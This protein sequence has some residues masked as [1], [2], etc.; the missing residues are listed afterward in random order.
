MRQTWSSLL[1]G[2]RK[3]A[4]AAAAG[5]ASP[6]AAWGCLGGR[7]SWL[8]GPPRWGSCHA[9][10]SPP[11]GACTSERTWAKGK[12]DL[13][14]ALLSSLW[15][16]FHVAIYSSES[17][18]AMTTSVWMHQGL[19][20]LP[21][22][23]PSGMQ[24]HLSGGCKDYCCFNSQWQSGHN[25]SYLLMSYT[26]LSW[27]QWPRS[28]TLH[29]SFCL[30]T[31]RLV[32]FC[33]SEEFSDEGKTS[34]AADSAGLSVGGCETCATCDAL[35]R[36]YSCLS[37]PTEKRFRTVCVCALN[38]CHVLIS[39][40]CVTS[41]MLGHGV[42]SLMPWHYLLTSKEIRWKQAFSCQC[43]LIFALWSCPE[44]WS[45]TGLFN[46]GSTAKTR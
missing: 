30:T 32:L 36:V 31:W 26:R 24:L 15:V 45:E 27:K 11:W 34:Q 46:G 40:C 3:T 35:R 14:K 16:C 21:C 17:R 2:R 37:L 33:S 25:G 1:I 39:A 19:Y 18:L 8:P 5:V 43:C 42:S 20:V 29:I 12:T 7:G 10:S 9:G 22:S 38:F 44:S 23:S 6:A 13:Q 4:S 41:V 28:K